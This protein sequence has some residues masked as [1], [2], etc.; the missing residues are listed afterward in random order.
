[1]EGCGG[2]EEEGRDVSSLCPRPGSCLPLISIPADCSAQMR[3]SRPSYF[4]IEGIHNMDSTSHNQ[5]R[6]M[7]DLVVGY[8]PIALYTAYIVFLLPTALGLGQDDMSSIISPSIQQLTAKKTR[9]AYHKPGTN[10]CSPRNS[11]LYPSYSQYACPATQATNARNPI[12]GF[13]SNLEFGRYSGRKMRYQRKYW[14]V[15]TL[16]K[17]TNANVWH[18]IAPERSFFARARGIAIAESTI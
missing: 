14:L 10:A 11:S 13:L 9:P 8:V 18:I 5:A 2:P 1:M 7:S 4:S 16:L 6:E 17:A 3:K 15:Q 12:Q